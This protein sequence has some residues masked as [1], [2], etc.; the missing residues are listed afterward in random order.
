[1]LYVLW[2]FSI[3]KNKNKFLL[4]QV[5]CIYK[6]GK[7]TNYVNLDNKINLISFMLLNHKIHLFSFVNNIPLCI[8]LKKIGDETFDSMENFVTVLYSFD[9]FCSLLLF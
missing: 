8:K 7:L 9:Y 5:G 2:T 1:M 4:L 3:Q 6:K